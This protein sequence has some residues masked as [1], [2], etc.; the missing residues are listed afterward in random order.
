MKKFIAATLLTVLAGGGA[1][2]WLWHDLQRVLH[3]PLEVRAP[4]VLHVAT[5][6][7]LRALGA[8]LRQRGWMQRPSYLEFEGRRSGRAASIKAGD[9]AVTPGMTPLGL[10]DLLVSGQV[11]QHQFT[12]IEGWSMRELL[13]AI[14]ASPLLRATLTG[15]TP[16]R[17]MAELGF[18]G[19]HAEGKFLPD[20]YYFPT[21]TTDLEFL[22][23]AHRALE[24]A[25]AE[26]WAGRSDGLPY[27][28][29]Y[30]ALIMASIIE[31]E[32][33]VP[34]ERARIAGVFVRRLQQG[35]RLQTDPTVIYALGD[36]FDGNIRRRDLDVESPYNTYRVAG[37]PPT[38]IALPGRDSIHAAL[39][40]EAG[41][42][43]YFVARGDGSHEF[44]A[45]LEDHNRAVRRYQ[46]GEQR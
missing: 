6:T 2:A 7:S 26:E 18:P 41:D 8:E 27:A 15:A 5:G 46:L 40:P 20:T 17:V 37:L 14:S 11:I 1:A 10:L 36:A 16:E 35:M 29:S 9:Y 45:T 24:S 28:D 19:Q 42:A 21:G 22:R 34:A 25:L 4:A 39:H 13:P 44:S 31:K 12:I 23:R 3:A 33:A 32:T 30:Q 43:L 38:P